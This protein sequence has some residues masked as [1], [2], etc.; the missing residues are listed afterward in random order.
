MRAS[1]TLCAVGPAPGRPR[2]GGEC[3]DPSLHAIPR[4]SPVSAA[5]PSDVLLVRLRKLEERL[6]QVTRQY[7]RLACDDQRLG[8]QYQRLLH[9]VRDPAPADGGGRGGGA[10]PAPTAGCGSK[11]SGGDS[12]T[13]GRIQEVGNPHLG[14]PVYYRLGALRK[15]N[16]LFWLRFQVYF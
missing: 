12:T 11:T 14:Q 1:G 15:T 16:D 4:S 2:A 3:P 5:P 6:D 7:E 13:T 8:R 10:G 9:E